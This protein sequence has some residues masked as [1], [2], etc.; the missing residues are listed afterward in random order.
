MHLLHPRAPRVHRAYTAYCRSR[1]KFIHANI[2]LCMCSVRVRVCALMCRYN[3]KLCAYAHIVL[4]AGIV[5]VHIYTGMGGCHK[6]RRVLAHTLLCAGAILT[7]VSQPRLCEETLLRIL[8]PMAL[9]ALTYT[10]IFSISV[11]THGHQFHVDGHAKLDKIQFVEMESA[12]CKWG[13]TQRALESCTAHYTA[14][15][16]TTCDNVAIFT[17]LHTTNPRHTP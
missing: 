1:K 7:N 9:Y 11:R 8:P 13:H 3:K 5:R 17:L 16:L 4:R 10:A 2:V 6:M 14:I 15:T 12:N